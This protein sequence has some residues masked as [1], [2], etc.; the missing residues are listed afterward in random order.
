MTTN[1][2]E[3]IALL[4]GNKLLSG[5]IFQDILSALAE[6]RFGE[7]KEPVQEYDVIIDEMNAFEKA[8]N[9]VFMQT[10]FEANAIYD[11]YIKQAE[12][13]NTAI[14][15]EFEYYAILKKQDALNALLWENISKRL[16]QTDHEKPFMYV[17]AGFKIVVNDNAEEPQEKILEEVKKALDDYGVLEEARAD[18][19]NVEIAVEGPNGAI[20]TDLIENECSDQAPKRVLN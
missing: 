14:R 4:N 11:Q 3:I 5:N 10:G 7:P 15:L 18:G 17:R 20:A 16:P 13:S 2:S 1:V 9:Y 12:G 19:L 6:G 8:I